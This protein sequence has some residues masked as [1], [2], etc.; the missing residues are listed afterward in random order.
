[1]DIAAPIVHFLRA[2][3]VDVLS[4][5]DEGW[6]DLTDSQILAQAHAMGRFVLTHDS[7][8][9]TLA[10]HRSEAIHRHSILASWG[11]STGCGDGGYPSSHGNRYRLE[12][13]GHSRVPCGTSTAQ[14]A[15]R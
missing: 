7:D 2:Q 8:F 9:G 1:M 3:G 11:S 13:T 4:A 14:E 15:F 6:G 10:V 5:R 12:A